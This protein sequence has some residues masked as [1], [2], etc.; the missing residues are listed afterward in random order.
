MNNAVD[1]RDFPQPVI[2][3]DEAGRGSLAGPVLAAA[4][5]LNFPET[6]W[7]S[8]SLS[9]ARREKLETIIKSHHQYGI[10]IASVKEI[11]ELNI[12][13]ASLLAMKRAVASLS[14]QKGH[15]LVDGKFEI[16]DLK[17]FSQTTLIQGDKRA[18]PI[19]AASILAKTARDKILRDYSKRYSLYQFDAHKG[20]A[21]KE[22]K[23][24]IRDYGPCPIHRKTFSGV[25]EYLPSQRLT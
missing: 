23:K 6:F 13:E 14:I 9:Q 12:H 18:D 1:Y 7:D 11:D 5:S 16:K 2:G 3:V 22:H 24:A 25:K 17:A 19:K 20:Y 21:T 8:K 10:G 15:V 4:V